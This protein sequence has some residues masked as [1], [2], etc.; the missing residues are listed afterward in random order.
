M[1]KFF[2]KN[3]LVKK[4]GLKKS[5]LGLIN[6]PFSNNIFNKNIIINMIYNIIIIL[7]KLQSYL[8]A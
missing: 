5:L 8:V 7:F 4:M 2:L 1:P 3:C 6:Y